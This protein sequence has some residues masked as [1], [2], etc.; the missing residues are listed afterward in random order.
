MNR[1]LPE[2][3]HIDLRGRALPELV[4]LY[5]EQI[6]RLIETATRRYTA[7]GISAADLIS[8]YWLAR[9]DNPYT[10]EIEEVARRVGRPGA[11]MLNLSF[12]WAC[13]T[14]VIPDADG[15]GAVLRRTLD[16]PLAELG[17]TLIAVT[18]TGR[19]GHYVSMTWPGFTG[20]LTGIARGRFAVA[21]NQPPMLRTGFGKVAD[22]AVARWKIWQ[23]P[24]LPPAHLL[25]RVLEECGDY[26]EARRMLAETPVALPV[27][28]T[29]AGIEES[30]GCVIERL[31][32]QAAIREGNVVAANHWHDFDFP[33][34]RGR[35]SQLRYSAM[36]D[37][38]SPAGT[39]DWLT[40]PV[41]NPDTRV[42]FEGNART[43]VFCLQG[44]EADGPVTAILR[45]SAP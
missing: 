27:F 8:R 2:I 24:A 30:E 12:E 25:R 45:S 40:P 35:Q 26:E 11:A 44:W 43:G 19:A 7:A 14:A 4:D 33:G 10:P 23:H 9:C 16:W 5:P 21:I 38:R 34:D 29:L 36:A 42:A 20:A 41:L 13:T 1:V 28:F 31:P 6:D 15:P 18:S 22:W 37:D 32:R 3:P 17:R 39:L